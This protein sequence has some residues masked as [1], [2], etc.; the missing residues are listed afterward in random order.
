MAWMTRLL[1]ALFICSTTAS[2]QPE[3][4]PEIGA[5]LDAFYGM[6]LNPEYQAVDHVAFAEF[7]DWSILPEAVLKMQLPPS[8]PELWT[9]WLATS[10]DGSTGPFLAFAGE[11]DD[12]VQICGAFFR[13]T[14]GMAFLDGFINETD[15][16]ELERETKFGATT[17]LFSMPEL[18]NVGVTIYV[19]R[20]EI[21]VR[22][23]AVFAN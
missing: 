17:V 5:A 2:A 15:A 1:P 18:G 14:N 10:P 21:D 12:D 3:V 9:G 7:M 8:K 19:P 23:F 6:C 4:E 20:D 16:V 22:A 13:H 11:G